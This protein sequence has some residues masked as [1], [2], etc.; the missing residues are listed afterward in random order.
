MTLLPQSF[1]TR[2]IIDDCFALA[3]SRPRVV[4]ELNGIAPMIELIKQT[5]LAGIIGASAVKNTTNLS[6]VSL[7]EP[8][9]CR[10]PGLLWRR[11]A[12]SSSAIKQFAN[13]VREVSEGSI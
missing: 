2:R 8:T 10:T 6:Q 9:P 1:T 11:G 3:K 13:V 12:P 5:Q 7:E 4:V